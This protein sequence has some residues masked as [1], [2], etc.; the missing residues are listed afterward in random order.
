VTPPKSSIIIGAFALALYLAGLLALSVGG[1]GP[2][3]LD[4]HMARG[5]RDADRQGY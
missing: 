1:A 5:T 3:S 4:G 2:L